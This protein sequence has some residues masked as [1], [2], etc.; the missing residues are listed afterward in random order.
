MIDV[1]SEMG[2]IEPIFIK[3]QGPS[4]VEAAKRLAVTYKHFE[5]WHAEINTVNTREMPGELIALY[6]AAALDL[7]KILAYEKEILS[8]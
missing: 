6:E 4:K 7:C 8:R 2:I 1:K 5:D 3:Q